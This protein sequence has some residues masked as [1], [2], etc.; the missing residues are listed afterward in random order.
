MSR[1]LLQTV[2]AALAVGTSLAFVSVDA[3]AAN[4]EQRATRVETAQ[5]TALIYGPYATMG[6]ANE[7]AK[8]FRSLGFSA[9][10]FHNGDGYYVK[11]W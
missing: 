5:A 7:V 3:S 1:K 2:I 9:F 4:V 8:E 6:R 10:A 11:V